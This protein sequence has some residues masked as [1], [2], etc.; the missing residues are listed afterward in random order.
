M[1]DHLLNLVRQ[2]RQMC[3]T[4]PG[5]PPLARYP[6]RFW[7]VDHGDL[8]AV[9]CLIA[10]TS[11]LWAITILCSDRYGAIAY[12]DGPNYIY[13]SI[14]LYRI[15][16]DYLWKQQFDYPASYFACHLPGF[17]LAIRL[18]STILLNNFFLGTHLAIFS[19]SALL[20][21]LFRRVLWIYDAVEHPAKA[22]A[23]LTIIPLRFMP[24]HTAP[25]SE[26]LYMV[27]ACLAFIFFRTNDLFFLFLAIAGACITRIEG[28]AL[29]GT[30]GLCYLLRWDI[31]R[32]VVIGFDLVATVAVFLLHHLRFGDWRAYFRFNQGHNSIL[33]FL[34]FHEILSGCA[35]QIELYKVAAL[36]L[37]SIFIVGVV[38][39]FPV[40]V[41]FGIFSLVYV[42]FVS[43]ISHM[44]IFRYALP[45]YIFAVFVGFDEV[46]SAKSAQKPLLVLLPFYL[47]LGVWY[48][49]GQLRTNTAGA[50]FTETVLETPI[51]YY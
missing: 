44:D 5:I 35:G 48:T 31:W 7:S 14:T 3:K 11:V 26:P 38:L 28:L 49:V 22:A 10:L 24:Y 20:L 18:F 4:L 46:W 42:W 37:F 17:P 32:A 40:S 33:Y 45:G 51:A 16:D 29:W 15:P 21:Y 27:Y 13:A 19:I 2:W 39:V 47:A 34:P 43:C 30:I 12:W 41:P 25:A 1:A 9:S 36:A 23:M 50:W 6:P 8:V